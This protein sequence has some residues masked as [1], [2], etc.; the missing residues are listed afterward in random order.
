MYCLNYLNFFSASV[1]RTL[2]E[3]LRKE[4]GWMVGEIERA[5]KKAQ[6][7][8]NYRY[9]IFTQLLERSSL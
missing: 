8:S 6:A 1:A 5:A 9:F 3:R 2:S 4:T 7:D